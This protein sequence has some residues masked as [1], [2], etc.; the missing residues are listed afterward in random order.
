MKKVIFIGSKELGYSVFEKIHHL[1]KES[2]KA[3]ITVDDQSDSRSFYHEFR[4]YCDEN[5]IELYVL[6][7]PKEINK[8]IYDLK[9]DLCFVLCWYF[10]IDSEVLKSVPMGFIGIHNSI[11]PSYRGFAPLVWT[12]INGE[13]KA[14][15]SLFNL[16]DEMDAG[17]IWATGE[18]I[19]DTKDYIGDVL[20]KINRK[21]LEVLE[22]KYI[23]LL[24]G[25]IFPQKQKAI[26]PSY[27]A[28]RNPEDGKINWHM[29][30]RQV[31]NFIRA[32]S[33][34]YPGAYTIYKGRKLIIWKADLCECLYYGTPG[35]VG[36]IINS[37]NVLVICGDSKGVIL[38]D[39]E[40][41]GKTIETAR[42]LN[43]LNIR[44]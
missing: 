17:E 8:I 41:D 28:K 24:N 7:R 36:Q 29:S 43:S 27:C 31:Y 3:C 25:Q 30:A 11:L 34:P 13:E 12:M 37:Q 6:N 33:H 19:I 35:Q 10:L 16:S 44:M 42:V 18:V 40:Y 21:I 32:Q 4:Q 22:E 15:F 39:I 20:G 2:I 5:K 26:S 14:G 9:P 1:D 38:Q 23:P